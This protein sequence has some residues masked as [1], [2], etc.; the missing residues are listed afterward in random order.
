MLPA[1]VE[2]VFKHA[3]DFDE[4]GPIHKLFAN[5]LTPFPR[6]VDK[7][8]SLRNRHTRR[9]AHAGRRKPACGGDPLSGNLH[10]RTRNYAEVDRLLEINVAV[11]S[12]VSLHIAHRRKTQIQ[13]G[14]RIDYS[15]NCLELVA[16]LNE[17]LLSI[18]PR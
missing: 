7:S 5:R 6:R 10:S 13:S 17:L 11:P 14:F 8:H 3:L 1:V 4:V 2:R 16:L 12:T 15:E 9:K 18:Q